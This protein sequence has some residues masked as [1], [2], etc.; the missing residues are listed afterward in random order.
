VSGAAIDV[1]SFFRRKNELTLI[2]SPDPDT[3]SS[4]RPIP[5]VARWRIAVHVLSAFRLRLAY[6]DSTTKS[7]LMPIARPESPAAAVP[8]SGY[9]ASPHGSVWSRYPSPLCRSEF[10]SGGCGI[11]TVRAL[12]CERTAMK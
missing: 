11:G 9:P 10:G 5:A 2:V 12:Y 1:S 8:R 4:D 3:A 6:A 7:Q